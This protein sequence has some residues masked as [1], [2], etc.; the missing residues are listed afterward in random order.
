MSVVAA[1]SFPGAPGSNKTLLYAGAAVAVLALAGGAL[2]WFKFRKGSGGGTSGVAPPPVLPPDTTTHPIILGGGGTTPERNWTLRARSLAQ[3]WPSNMEPFL[4]I[5]GI[6]PRTTIDGAP[7]YSGGPAYD[8]PNEGIHAYAISRTGELLR[9]TNRCGY[10]AGVFVGIMDFIAEM[11]VGEVLVIITVKYVAE[12]ISSQFQAWAKSAGATKIER[13]AVNQSVGDVG[14]GRYGFGVIAVK[15]GPSSWKAVRHS[16][17]ER[18]DVVGEN[19]P[20]SIL[21]SNKAEIYAAG[22]L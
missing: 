12:P 11:A 1:P 3:P 5:D 18:A 22:G 9:Y 21:S 16:A 14:Y 2:W 17:S 15:T 10:R 20:D 7:V 6:R 8:C 13:L 4:E 19:P